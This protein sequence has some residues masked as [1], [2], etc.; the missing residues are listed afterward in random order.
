MPWR[1]QPRPGSA[2]RDGKVGDQGADPPLDVV[3]LME[4]FWGRMQPE[5]L[6]RQRWKTRIELANAV[7]D[8]LEIFR[9][10]QRRH[11]SLGM[12]SPCRV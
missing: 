7:F 12:L 9:N 6:D 10:R 2:G 8:Y 1:G 4:S 3:G 11:S 5:L